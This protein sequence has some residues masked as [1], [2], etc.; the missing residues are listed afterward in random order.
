MPKEEWRMGEGHREWQWPPRGTV[1]S[2][3]RSQGGDR[4]LTLQASQ[5]SHGDGG[6][7]CTASAAEARVG[8]IALCSW[9]QLM[10]K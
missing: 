5:G 2:G 7:Q 4:V 8:K 1:H 9:G 3:V 6:G 10:S